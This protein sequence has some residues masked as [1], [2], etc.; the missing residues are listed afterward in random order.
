MVP[1]VMV[2]RDFI[3]SS[4]LLPGRVVTVSRCGFEGVAC[5]PPSAQRSGCR[6]AEPVGTTQF[7]C[8]TE[9]SLNKFA[10]PSLLRSNFKVSHTRY[11][12]IGPRNWSDRSNLS[13]NMWDE[14]SEPDPRKLDQIDHRRQ[15]SKLT[16]R[17]DESRAPEVDATTPWAPEKFE[18]RHV[19]GS[20]A[21]AAPIVSVHPRS[22]YNGHR[23]ATRKIHGLG[24]KGRTS[25]VCEIHVGLY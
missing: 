1:N 12:D 2:D 5:G 23:F 22:P 20:L 24:D 21:A 13:Q 3:L 25:G 14:R 6:L 4:F 9:T 18:R 15:P 8:A 16:Q 10:G 7:G 19:S 17:Q 11:P